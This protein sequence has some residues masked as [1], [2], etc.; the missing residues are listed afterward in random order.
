MITCSIELYHVS[1]RFHINKGCVQTQFSQFSLALK[2]YGSLIC[3]LATFWIPTE[4]DFQQPRARGHL[5]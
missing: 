4:P 5:V 1:Y 3:N 2:D